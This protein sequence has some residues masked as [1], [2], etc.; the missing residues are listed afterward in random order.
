MLGKQLHQDHV[1]GGEAEHVA[2]NIVGGVV[3]L[4]A[5]EP[6][7]EDGDSYSDAGHRDDEDGAEEEV[8]GPRR[9]HGEDGGVRNLLQ[10]RVRARLN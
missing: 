10:R 5:A 8:L 3:Q 7:L 2:D 9:R 6:E 4:G 1:N